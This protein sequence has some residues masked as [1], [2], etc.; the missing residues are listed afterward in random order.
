MIEPVVSR[1]R[2]QDLGARVVYA[3]VRWYLDG[4]SGR[5]AYE[6]GHLPGAVFV[7]LDAVLARHGAPEEGR[8]PLPDPETFAAGM[9]AL[10]IGDDDI[11]VAYDD[12]GGVIAARLVWMLR[13]TGHDAALLDGG[14]LGYAGELVREEP[15]RPEATFTPRPW[16]GER[17]ADLDDVTDGSA[18]VVD[19]RDAGR[20][21][22]AVEP[23]D[24]RAGHIPG[25]RSLPCRENVGADSRFLP[26]EQLR[27][28]FRAVGAGAGTISYCGSGVTACHNLIALEH[29][30]LGVGRLY[31]GSWSAY[32]NTDRPVAT[33]D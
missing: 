1:R 18:V 4:R 8:H 32:S 19:A 28:R 12:G 11:V 27:E 9:A 16:P 20:F 7:D 13:A 15:Q 25:A 21:R 10:G 3:D 31:P 24:P 30:G 23:V 29:A 2:A 6:E 26:V 17:L 22:G 14:L 33:G 5:A